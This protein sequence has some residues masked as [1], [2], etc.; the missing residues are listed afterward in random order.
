[1]A[2][3]ALKIEVSIDGGAPIA[4]TVP[5]Q[6]GNAAWVEGVLSNLIKVAVPGQLAS[7]P[8]RIAVTARS[9]GIIALI[10]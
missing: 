5:R 8:H 4:L 10:A 9:G 1:M 6:V 2:M 3:I 7:G